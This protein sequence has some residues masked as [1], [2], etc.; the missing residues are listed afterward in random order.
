MSNKTEKQF[1]REELL[2]I[3][4]TTCKNFVNQLSYNRVFY[5]YK[6]HLKLTLLVH[7]CNNCIDSAVLNWCHLFNSH[8]DRLHW[9]KIVNTVKIDTFRQELLHHV[10]I[11]ENDWKE[12]RDKIKDYRGDCV[13][14][15][16]PFL[17]ID[18][19]PEMDIAMKAVD[20]YYQYI[21]QELLLDN[22]LLYTLPDNLNEYYQKSFEQTEKIFEL[23]Y[24][25]T[26][27]I[28]EQV[29]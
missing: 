8:N 13:S 27:H 26:K 6:D 18:K 10:S 9:K 23:I 11:T 28:K 15:I 7:I 14:H 29:F 20:Y 22:N 16:N 5:K 19:I 24:T 17:Y 21:L 1:S 25:A 4:G 3:V 12:Y 2:I